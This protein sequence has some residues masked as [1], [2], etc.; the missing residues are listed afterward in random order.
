[1]R[2]KWISKNKSGNGAVWNQTDKSSRNFFHVFF[3]DF[4]IS[5][6]GLAVESKSVVRTWSKSRNNIDNL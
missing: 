5:Y 2:Q 1:M 4:V 3:S 6:A